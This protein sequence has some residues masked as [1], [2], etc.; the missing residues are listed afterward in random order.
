MTLV[1]LHV[2]IARVADALERIV[3]LLDKLVF[4]VPAEPVTVQQATLDDLHITTE[5]DVVRM[6]AEQE[7]LA[8]RFRVTPGSPAMM[9]ALV[10]WEDQQRSIHGQ[11]WKAP[12]DW[13]AIFAGI[14]RGQLREPA[15]S[16]TAPAAD[17]R[18]RPKT[19]E[20]SAR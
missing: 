18:R 19:T 17:Q 5:E 7:E 11:E 1:E 13:R 8:E 4:P 3:F 14:E 20:T 15:G 12:E 10:A 2:D 6:R 16:G 9:Q